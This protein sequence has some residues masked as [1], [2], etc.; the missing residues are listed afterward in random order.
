M[1]AVTDIETIYLAVQ[2]YLAGILE[3]HVERLH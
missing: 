3:N 2:Q 1:A